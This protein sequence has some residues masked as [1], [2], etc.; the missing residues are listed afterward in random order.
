MTIPIE[1][2]RVTNIGITM[3]ILLLSIS[4]L[5]MVGCSNAK[6]PSQ[7]CFLA[8]CDVVNITINPE[9]PKAKPEPSKPKPSK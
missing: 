5:I 7:A 4:L 6:K 8:S 1:L 2:N 9:E 3:K